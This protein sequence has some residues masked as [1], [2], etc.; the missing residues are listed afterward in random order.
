MDVLINI[1][2]YPLTYI[3]FFG[4]VTYFLSVYFA[5]KVNTWT[6]ITGIISGILFFILYL[7]TNTY[8]NSFLQLILIGVS[9][10]GWIKWGKKDS[11]NISSLSNINRL[12]IFVISI[13]SI[14]CLGSFINLLPIAPDPYPYL[15]MSIFVLSIIGVILLAYKKIESWYV[16]IIINTLTLILYSMLGFYFI[17]IQCIILILLDFIALKEWKNYE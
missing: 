6:W 12:Y 13:V 15:D 11:K 7:Y 3:E 8:A 16:W 2:G 5:M 1:F 17:G 4:V 9:I 10:D 14:L